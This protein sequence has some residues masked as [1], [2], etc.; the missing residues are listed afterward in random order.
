MM[1]KRYVWMCGIGWFQKE[2]AN[3]EPLQFLEERVVVHA[4]VAV[5]QNR[6]NLPRVL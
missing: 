3:L 5:R 4:V 6:V 1:N 2:C